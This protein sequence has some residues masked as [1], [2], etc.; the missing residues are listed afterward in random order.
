MLAWLGMLPPY[1]SLSWYDGEQEDW[2]LPSGRWNGGI[3]S[4]PLPSTPA[5]VLALQAL[6][7]IPHHMSEG[8]TLLAAGP[9]TCRCCVRVRMRSALLCC[10]TGDGGSRIPSSPWQ[11]DTSAARRYARCVC[12]WVGSAC[13]PRRMAAA[14]PIVVAVVNCKSLC[15]A[16]AAAANSCREA[17]KPPSAFGI[18]C[19]FKQT[20]ETGS[21]NG[22]LRMLPPPAA[23]LAESPLR[24]QGTTAG[25]ARL[26]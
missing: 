26:P 18:C 13:R 4:L 17:P 20:V 11:A 10:G 2:T 14:G 3:T 8:S 1:P 23:R 25:P 24:G 7:G 6:L 12:V 9:K 22:R 19:C 5:A 16:I 15:R 21:P